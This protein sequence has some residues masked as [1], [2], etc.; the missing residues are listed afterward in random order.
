M[1]GNKR[2]KRLFSAGASTL[3]MVM[4]MQGSW[5]A[6]TA[7]DQ[8]VDEENS[9][10]EIIITGSRIRRSEFSKPIPVT[11]LSR[12]DIDA[13][14]V[15]SL[16]NLLLELPALTPDVTSRNAQ[17][18]TERAGVATASLRD[19]GTD[20]TLTLIDGKRVVS[21]RTGQLQ[22]D[23]NSIPTDFIERIEVLTGGASAIYG[24]DAMAGVVNIITKRDFEGLEV[25]VRG[26]LPQHG[27]E[28]D[29]TSSVT[30][31]GFFADGKGHAMF[32]ASFYKRYELAARGRSF[33]EYPL[34]IDPETNE[35]YRDFSTFTSGGRYEF[36]DPDGSS[37]SSSFRPFNAAGG[38]TA[39]R[40][41][42][43]ESGNTVLNA[44]NN[45]REIGFNYNDFATITIPIERF[46]LAGKMRYELTEGVEFF[47][48]GYFATT[49]STSNRTPET[50]RASEFNPQSPRNEQYLSI[51][52]ALV[53]QSLRDQALALG[54]G[55]GDADPFRDANGDPTVLL[56]WR[57][58][59]TEFG[60]RTTDNIRD[61]MRIVTG[62]KG[63]INDNFNWDLSYT[64]G[65]TIQSQVI[66]GNTQIANVNEALNVE[67]D[68]NNPGGFRCADPN[69]RARG[70]APLNIFGFDKVSPE[71][72]NWIVDTS[73]F[74]GRVEQSVITGVIDGELFDLPAGPVGFATG[75]EYRKDQSQTLT[76]SL[77]NNQ[78]TTF[79]A[80]PNNGGSM[81]V[82][83]AFTEV[84]VP[85]FSGEKFAEYL[86]VE[87]AVRIA[88]YST[89]GS[90]VS[91]KAGLEYAPVNSFRIRAGYS[92]AQRAPNIL[93]AFSVPR[94]TAIS[95]PDD[96]CDGVD[97]NTTG[98]VADNC[99]S[100]PTV[101]A[102][103]NAE[104]VFEQDDEIL[105]RGFNLGNTN[106]SE[107][108]SDTYTL[109]FVYQPEFIPGLGLTVDYYNIKIEGAIEGS[110]RD[111]SV[112][113]CFNTSGLATPDCALISRDGVGQIDRVD[114]EPRNQDSL[115]TEGIDAFLR[116]QFEA[117]Q[118]FDAL[119]GSI[120]MQANYTHTF[121]NNIVRILGTGELEI[122]DENNEV[123]SPM[124]RLRFQTSYR[125]GKFAFTYRM[126]LIGGALTDNQDYEDAVQ[127]VADGD[128]IPAFLERFKVSTQTYHSIS[129]SYNFG[130]DGQYQVFGGINN[131]FDNKPPLITPD[132]GNGRNDC[133]SYCSLY[134]PVGRAFYMGFRVSL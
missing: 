3:A 100:I 60:G 126:N 81:S 104:G 79:V 98:T 71:A 91:Y 89:V 35:V 10:D 106:L 120:S 43:D 39:A 46:L 130:Y 93:E 22:V 12:D 118:L 96:P 78:G 29:I 95:R 49:E 88:D 99:R 4:S 86:G 69:A 47:L 1:S 23:I 28:E 105:V 27:G 67:A 122:T 57:R 94:T 32:N 17:N 18:G 128:A 68:P 54:L 111:Q 124:D 132:L 103:I 51:N 87:G 15:E 36:R 41:F 21:S 109:G 56:D 33:S 83:E 119:D 59:L 90:V 65:R 63:K 66:R 9:L 84:L 129:A 121:T 97:L 72:L 34:E 134:D 58:R 82:K 75:I 53:P 45:H 6:A 92:R 114:S 73:Q 80:V 7:Q 19:L 13:S 38:R 25:R 48:D 20:R 133:N 131:L 31:G 127:D 108:S 85:L 24:S 76:D 125:D 55:D 5:A 26:S 116:Y 14:G 110:S 102:A 11:S 107:E 42:L 40:Y 16:E 50:I 37:I 2:I 62:F 44:D 64:Y 101:L 74:R 123:D 113:S 8:A 117:S 70:C 61:T 112:E 115:K 30:G 77:L 52:H